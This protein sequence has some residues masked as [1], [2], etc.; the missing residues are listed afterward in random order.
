MTT[1]EVEIMSAFCFP[2]INQQEEKMNLEPNNT[3]LSFAEFLDAATRDKA[4]AKLFPASVPFLLQLFLLNSVTFPN[5]KLLR[6]FFRLQAW[7]LDI[8]NPAPPNLTAKWSNMVR[9]ICDMLL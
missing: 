1:N 9:P 5:T 4:E 6:S 7:N 2:E 3:S 8:F